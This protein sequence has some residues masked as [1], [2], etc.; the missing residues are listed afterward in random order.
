M[1]WGSDWVAGDLEE[2]GRPKSEN[3]QQGSEDR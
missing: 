2:S 1:F 3:F